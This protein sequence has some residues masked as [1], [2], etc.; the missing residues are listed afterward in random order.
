MDLQYRGGRRLLNDGMLANFIF[1]WWMF[2][3]LI[4]DVWMWVNFW[5]MD[6]AI[7]YSWMLDYSFW[8]WM[9][10]IDT[11]YFQIFCWFCH[12]FSYSLCWHISYNTRSMYDHG[13]QTCQNFPWILV[14][15]LW[16]ILYSN[17][18]THQKTPKNKTSLY[19]LILCIPHKSLNYCH[20]WNSPDD[21]SHLATRIRE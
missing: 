8:F 2:W 10:D 21:M 3:K 19:F 12:V 1:G 15:S 7:F 13:K 16:P 11:R 6:V 18:Q 4:L 9:M 20:I 5:M 14:D 17:T